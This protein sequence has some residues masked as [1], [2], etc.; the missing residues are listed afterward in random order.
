MDDSSN[1]TWQDVISP[2]NSFIG[3]SGAELIMRESNSVSTE[4]AITNCTLCIHSPNIPG[5]TI[6]YCPVV[7]K[8]GLRLPE[9][10]P[11]T[12]RPSNPTT[13]SP[14]PT[15]TTMRLSENSFERGSLLGLIQRQVATI[16][17]MMT[18]GIDELVDTVSQV[19]DPIE[20]SFDASV[21]SSPMPTGWKSGLMRSFR[22]ILHVLPFDQHDDLCD[23]IDE[24]AKNL[25][26]TRDAVSYAMFLID[27]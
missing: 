19:T 23:K 15:K 12:K 27:C 21:P 22:H 2:P 10:N 13:G 20:T 1:D 14:P 17:Q 4:P 24:M 18:H 11:H 26:T 3:D 6:A 5:H 9:T 16:Q 25:K 8:L 7:Q